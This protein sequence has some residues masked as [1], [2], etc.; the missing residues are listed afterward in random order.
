M[1]GRDNV[2]IRWEKQKI[3]SQRSWFS[4]FIGI[5]QGY[6]IT[7]LWVW[8][9]SDCGSFRCSF[10]PI[11]ASPRPWVSCISFSMWPQLT[12]NRPYASYEK[13]LWDLVIKV[14]RIKK[15]F[16]LKHVLSLAWLRLAWVIWILLHLIY[17]GSRVNL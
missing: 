16:Y 14:C 5:S 11:Y 10:F 4:R 3:S 2:A 9:V 8:I 17:E 13:G 12:Y 15:Y 7:A 6:S 1:N